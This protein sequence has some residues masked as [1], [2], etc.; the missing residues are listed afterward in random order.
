MHIQSYAE[1][2][3]NI[4][5]GVPEDL[6]TMG[7]VHGG[8]SFSQDTVSGMQDEGPAFMMDL[9]LHM[10]LESVQVI[11]QPSITAAV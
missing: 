3:V 1:L 11:S 8:S 2:P 5:S 9:D 7:M 10:Q 6:L 4:A